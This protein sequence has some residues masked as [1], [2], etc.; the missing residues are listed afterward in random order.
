MYSIFFFSIEKCEFGYKKWIH[1][2][3]IFIF[4]KMNT[5]T[6]LCVCVFKKEK[7]QSLWAHTLVFSFITWIFTI[8]PLLSWNQQPHHQILFL[9]LVRPPSLSLSLVKLAALFSFHTEWSYW[10]YIYIYIHTQI[11]IKP[12]RFGGGCGYGDGSMDF[13]LGMSVIVVMVMVVVMV[14]LVL[15]WVWVKWW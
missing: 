5:M 4:T 2:F 13:D 12:I 10:I 6:L 1:I 15:I 14:W 8:P 9:Y 7:N 11:C 3:T